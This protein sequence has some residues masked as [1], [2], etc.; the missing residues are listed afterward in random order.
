MY[1]CKEECKKNVLDFRYDCGTVTM[2]F[3]A[4]YLAEQS[5]ICLY[6]YYRL[7][8]RLFVHLHA[9]PNPQSCDDASTFA[10]CGAGRYCQIDITG[11]TG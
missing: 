5:F 10:G 11:Y 3:L 1:E 6:E 4:A 2:H 8:Q 7:S 9:V